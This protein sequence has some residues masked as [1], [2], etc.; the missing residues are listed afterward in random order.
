MRC[1]VIAV[2]R[3]F[4][5]AHLWGPLRPPR[6]SVYGC[7]GAIGRNPVLIPPIPLHPH[8]PFSF[9]LTA[10]GLLAGTLWAGPA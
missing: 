7:R 1:C 3:A 6:F 10:R 2:E 4:A 8:I 9:A 5:F